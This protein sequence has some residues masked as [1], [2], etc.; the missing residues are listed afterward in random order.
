MNHSL[1]TKSQTGKL[2]LMTFHLMILSVVSKTVLFCY[3]RQVAL[4]M[5]F[6]LK[7]QK[8]NYLHCEVN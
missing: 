5:R 7:S 3:A 2:N 1:N 8:E 4:Y 6:I